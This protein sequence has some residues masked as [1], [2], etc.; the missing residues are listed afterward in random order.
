MDKC[1]STFET[2]F[3]NDKKEKINHIKIIKLKKPL[4]CIIFSYFIENK[5]LKIIRNNKNLQKEIGIDIKKYKQISKRYKIGERNGKG[6]EYLKYNNKMIFEGEYLNGKRNGKG[7]EYDEEG[8]LIFTG[9]YLNGKRNG[10][11]KEYYFNGKLKF[12]GNYSNGNLTISGIIPGIN[13][14]DKT[15]DYISGIIIGNNSK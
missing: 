11:G 9:E 15:F 12:E 4:L 6:K 1:C 7:N 8:N 13:K 10:K 3:T 5:K 2:L 14:D